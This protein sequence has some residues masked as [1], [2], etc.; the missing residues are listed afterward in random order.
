MRSRSGRDACRLQPS[1]AEQRQRPPLKAAESLPPVASA[2][3]PWGPRTELAWPAVPRRSLE[4]APPAS[5]EAGLQAV[6]GGL[7]PSASRRPAGAL[8][9][10]RGPRLSARPRMLRLRRPPA[11]RGR[12]R[13]EALAHARVA[14]GGGGRRMRALSQPPGTPRG[15]R[16]PARARARSLARSLARSRRPRL[17]R[18][19]S[20]SEPLRRVRASSPGRA[21]SPAPSAPGPRPAPPPPGPA[22]C[23]SSSSPRGM[24]PAPLRVARPGPGSRSVSRCQRLPGSRRLALSL[25]QWR[26]RLR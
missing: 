2:G 9:A 1:G 10:R 22:A 5:G 12:G 16:A 3:S 25:S 11:Q 23:P 8:P 21:E 20:L 17:P 19:R 18:L 6:E 15:A 24:G 4:A 14:V 26:R 13:G 7:R